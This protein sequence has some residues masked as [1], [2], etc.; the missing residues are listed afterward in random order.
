MK[1]NFAIIIRYVIH[2]Y[3]F[4]L[5]TSFPQFISIGKLDYQHPLNMFSL[6]YSHDFNRLILCFP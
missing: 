2:E 6:G 1:G 4:S 3:V 5:F